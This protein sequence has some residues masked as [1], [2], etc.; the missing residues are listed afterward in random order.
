MSEPEEKKVTHRVEIS[1]QPEIDSLHEDLAKAKAEQEELKSKL[2][3]A[4]LNEVERQKTELKEKYPQAKS[5]IDSCTDGSMLQDLESNL[6]DSYG[7]GKH[8]PY[9]KASIIPPKGSDEYSSQTEMVDKLYDTAY[10]SSQKYTPEEVSE[11]KAK[12][13]QLIRSMIGGQGWKEMRERNSTNAIEKHKLSACPKC[14]FTLVDTDTCP[15]CHY[16]PKTKQTV[17]D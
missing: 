8:A 9:G 11:A 3:L 2:E 12:I 5:L 13:E 10:F 6:K 7:T 16:N 14:H 1:R 17:R 4:A 15:N